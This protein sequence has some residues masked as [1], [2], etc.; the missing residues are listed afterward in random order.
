M[1]Y[2]CSNLNFWGFWFCLKPHI[3]TKCNQKYTHYQRQNTPLSVQQ[4]GSLQENYLHKQ[5][6]QTC[7]TS[8]RAMNFGNSQRQ[9]INNQNHKTN[10]K[11]AE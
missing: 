6:S 11:T 1:L 7:Q 2:T 10:L 8:N 9:N 5:I 4:I 3:P